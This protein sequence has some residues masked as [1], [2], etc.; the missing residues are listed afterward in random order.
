[1]NALSRFLFESPF[2]L[3]A[4]C[5]VLVAGAYV[6]WLRSEPPWRGRI[7]PAI[8]ALFCLLFAVQAIV[9]TEREEIRAELDA[10]LRAVDRKDLA[11]I[12]A[13]IAPE[14]ADPD[15]DRPGL[16]A[17]IES[18]LKD[19][20]VFDARIGRCDI[21]I[22]DGQAAMDLRAGA[23]VRLRGVPARLS[24][25]WRIDWRRLPGGWRIT[26]LHPSDVAGRSVA[27]LRD[28]Y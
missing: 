20:D 17:W 5:L 4:A 18:T 23:T 8:V 9:T 14:Y 12:A 3:A 16:L 6:A 1:M 25:R 2:Q 7:G 26:A 13:V 10:L 21:E 28:L 19:V 22:A 27:R 15:F 24:T 11:A